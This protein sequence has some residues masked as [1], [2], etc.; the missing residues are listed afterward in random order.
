MLIMKTEGLKRQWNKLKAIALNIKRQG[1]GARSKYTTGN[2]V[3]TENAVLSAVRPDSK[4]SMILQDSNDL[5]ACRDLLLTL[6]TTELLLH[7]RQL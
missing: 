5:S 2:M 6:N 3:S 4:C 1:N 7:L